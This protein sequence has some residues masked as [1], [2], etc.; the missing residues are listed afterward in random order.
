ML[1]D[2]HVKH[3]VDA[4]QT[5]CRV[6]VLVDVKHIEFF[7][8]VCNGTNNYVNHFWAEIWKDLEKGEIKMNAFQFPIWLACKQSKKWR[9]FK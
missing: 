7:Q 8:V 5:K 6:P 3:I 1:S 2:M 9:R 4:K